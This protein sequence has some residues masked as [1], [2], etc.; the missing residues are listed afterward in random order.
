MNPCWRQDICSSLAQPRISR[1][2]A[3]SFRVDLPLDKGNRAR[4]TQRV[5][6][7]FLCLKLLPKYRAWRRSRFLSSIIPTLTAAIV[8]GWVL[9]S[10]TLGKWTRL[11]YFEG[12]IG[13][14]VPL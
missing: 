5:L 7:C 11:G 10:I 3:L 13:G 8:G 1:H 4:R 12:T 6:L 14:E 2:R 9:L